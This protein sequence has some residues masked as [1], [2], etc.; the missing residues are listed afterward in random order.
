MPQVAP[1]HKKVYH[2]VLQTVIAAYEKNKKTREKLVTDIA[3]VS[4][5]K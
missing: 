5:A 1:N 4:N 3:D 2:T